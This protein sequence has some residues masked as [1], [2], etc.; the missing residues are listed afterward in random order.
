MKVNQELI[1][2]YHRQECSP[3][4]NEAVEEWLFSGDADEALQLPAG[5]DKAAHKLDMWHEIQLVLPQ[6][7]VVVPLKKPLL[8][9]AFWTGAVAASVA[10]VMV[11]FVFYQVR[12]NHKEERLVSVQNS[13]AFEV[14]HVTS[15]GYNI[16]V[17]PKTSALINRSDRIIDLSGSII[18]KP[19]EDIEF[20]FG[21]GQ[22]K[23]V[24]KNGETYIVWNDMESSGKI[25]IINE[26]NL[27]DLPPVL[28]KQIINQFKI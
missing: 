15:N 1:E 20:A 19:T 26:R 2:R 10:L 13:S 3:E 4:E 24:F 12:F 16:A 7:P 23:I 14:K 5:E 25:I 27:T 28:Q 21:P 17:G 18:I 8:G 9:R 6:D 11:T 22:E